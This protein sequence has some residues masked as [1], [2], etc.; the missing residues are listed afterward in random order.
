MFL[1][2]PMMWKHG[3][4]SSLLGLVLHGVALALPTDASCAAVE[5][6]LVV[7]LRAELVEERCE[8]VGL[9][10]R[11]PKRKERVLALGVP[12][13]VPHVARRE[14]RRR[15]A[16]ARVDR[17][18]AP[19]VGI[20]WQRNVGEKLAS[21]E[22]AVAGGRGVVIEAGAQRSG[23]TDG[24]RRGGRRARAR[25]VHVWGRQPLPT[26]SPPCRPRP[27]TFVVVA[28]RDAGL[29]GGTENRPSSVSRIPQERRTLPHPLQRPNYCV[30][31][32]HARG[33]Y[34]TLSKYLRKCLPP[35]GPLTICSGH[36]L[37]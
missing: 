24:R 13:E 8:V 5:L 26:S 6:V 11:A 15:R 37:P 34:G 1:I 18:R 7:D 14:R 32:A 31:L 17:R 9:A 35:R 36:I 22:L 10:P 2:G 27:Q 12:V 25:D 19:S 30:R 28:R 23:Y 29:Q 33:C 3:K 21:D 20:K 4:A 16:V